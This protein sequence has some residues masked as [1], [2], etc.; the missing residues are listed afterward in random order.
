LSGDEIEPLEMLADTVAALLADTQWGGPS[1]L[2]G[3]STRG[4]ATA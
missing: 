1:E 4:A 2:V 3:L